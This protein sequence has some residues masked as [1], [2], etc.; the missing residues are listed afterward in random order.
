MVIL[1]TQVSGNYYSLSSPLYQLDDGLLDVQG[2]ISNCH[3]MPRLLTNQGGQ[4]VLVADQ[5]GAPPPGGRNTAAGKGG[6]GKPGRK[7]R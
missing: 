4:L 2:H 3:P 1:T 7:Q 5:E 6:K